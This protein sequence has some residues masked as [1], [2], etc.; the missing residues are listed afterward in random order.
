[1]F[2]TTKSKKEHQSGSSYEMNLLM[3]GDRV[4]IMWFLHAN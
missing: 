1:M 3:I 4:L 2:F